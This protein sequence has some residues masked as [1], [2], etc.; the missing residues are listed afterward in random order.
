M[1][2][3]SHKIQKIGITINFRLILNKLQEPRPKK[4]YFSRGIGVNKESHKKIFFKR[5]ALSLIILLLPISVSAG[6]ISSIGIIFFK[7]TET[8]FNDH[9]NNLQKMKLLAATNTIISENEHNLDQ[10]VEN[11]L[12]MASNGP[13]GTLLDTLIHKPKSDQISVY[14]VR[15]GD[16]LSQI[17]NMFGVDINT[18][19]WSNDLTSN[20]LKEGQTLVILPVSGIKHKVVKGDTLDSITKKYKGNKE[21][22]ISY[23]GLDSSS[24]LT[25]GS[26]IIIPDGELTITNSSSQT[27][28]SAN[29]KPSNLKDIVDYYMRP[30]QG[31]KRSQ[32]LHGYNAVDLAAPLGT[33]IYAAADGEVIVSRSGGWNGGY[34]TY[35]V[36]KHNNGTQ[37]LYAHNNSNNVSVGDIVKK[38]DVIGTIGKTGKATG[39]HLHFEIRGAKNPF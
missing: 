6:L 32:G 21:E 1:A 15:E 26:T 22:I 31:G 10:I 18:I 27:S 37:T 17:A 34:G 16:T 35:I 5:L 20:L 23:N 39:V 8:D 25:I 4:F 28:F 19:K 33:P 38:G 3:L 2:L 14:V 36:I 29:I 30:I 9:N 24:P 7:T 12:L 11:S 13:E